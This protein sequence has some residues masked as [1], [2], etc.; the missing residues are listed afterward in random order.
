MESDLQLGLGPKTSVLINNYN[1]APFLR[2]CVESVLNQSLLPDEI[3]VADDGSTDGS[4]EILREYVPQI[5][6]LELP[7]GTGTPVCNQAIAIE[8]A[9]RA[10]TGELVFF[11]DGDDAFL[12]GKME[13]YVQ[14]FREN[15][16]A[17]MIQ[18]PLEKIDGRGRPRGFEYESPRHQ[19]DYLQHIY[20]THE[21]NIYYPTSSLAFSRSYLEAR[22]PLDMDDG[23]PIWPDARL[24]LLAPHFGQIVTL[25]RPYTYWRR[26]AHS[27]TV[28]KPVS[29]YDLVRLNQKYFNG[30]CRRTG[31]PTIQPWKSRHHRRRVLRHFLIP[32]SL[33]QTYRTVRWMTLSA[34]KRRELLNGPTEAD[35]QREEERMRREMIKVRGSET[36]SADLGVT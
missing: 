16:D 1:N 25:S 6:L 23:L 26:H 32:D 5:T 27:H 20:T 13:A 18:A 12:P 30:F 11:L 14:A 22:F 15:R 4:L 28:A 10:S 9:L 33:M 31:R 34:E 8:R 24:T 36:R 19:V 3:I 7:H 17:V 35:L 2:Q 29:M 21:L